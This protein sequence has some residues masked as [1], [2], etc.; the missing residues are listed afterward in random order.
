[1][2]CPN[3]INKQTQT[4]SFVWWGTIFLGIIMTAQVSDGK[5]L[6]L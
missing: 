2:D 3:N 1:M 5:N 6:L 4:S